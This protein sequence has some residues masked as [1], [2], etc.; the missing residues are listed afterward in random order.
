LEFRAGAHILRRFGLSFYANAAAFAPSDEEI[1]FAG[2]QGLS[3]T[4][5]SLVSIG[6]AASGGTERGKFGAQG[7][8]GVSFVRSFRA[9]ISGPVRG[10][11]CSVDVQLTG[12]GLRLGA[13]FNIPLSR[14]FQLNPFSTLA[15]GGFNNLTVTD[16]NGCLRA[17]A[18]PNARLTG[19][20]K[21]GPT[22]F[23][24]SL[25]VGGEYFIGNE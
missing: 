4:D 15:F 13:A 16:K 10:D 21:D 25:G 3:P 8:F 20:I 1:A 19:E 7:E 14:Q 6:L 23:T 18:G 9:E 12:L 22:N 11:Q 24:F 2:V 17:A 5:P